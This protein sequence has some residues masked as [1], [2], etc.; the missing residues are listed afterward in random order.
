M[1]EAAAEHTRHRVLDLIISGVGILIEESLGSHNDSAD[2]ESALRRLFLDKRLLQRV[3]P[4]NGPEAFQ[5]CYLDAFDGLHRGDAGPDCLVFDDHGTG[6]ALAEPAAELRSAQFQIIAQ[7]VKQ[8]RCRI[9]VQR[10]R[11]AINL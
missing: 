4:V 10:M 9:H 2:A 3:R 11:P 8:R 6:S 1:R 7:G 5:S